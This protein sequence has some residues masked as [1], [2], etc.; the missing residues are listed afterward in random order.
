MV[1]G[2]ELAEAYVL[3]KHYR[4]EKRETEKG[5]SKMGIKHAK[6]HIISGCFSWFLKRLKRSTLIR[7]DH[8]RNS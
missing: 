1:G 4:E 2:A 7:D 8:Q 6:T 3:R 5:R